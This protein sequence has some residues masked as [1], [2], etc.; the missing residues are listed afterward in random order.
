MDEFISVCPDGKPAL[1]LEDFRKFS[2]KELQGILK[3]YH[4]NISEKK[5]DLLMRTFAIFSRCQPKLQSQQLPSDS[6]T[7]NTICFTYK[8][9]FSR[10]LSNAIWKNDIREIPN[11]YFFQLYHYFVVITEKYNGDLLRRTSYKRLKLFQFFYEGYIK[12]MELFTTELFIYV[13]FKAKPSMKNKCY[14]VIVKFI[15][16]SERII[17]AACTCPAGSSI[18]CL[19]K[20]N[21][22]GATLFALEDFNRKDFKTFVEPLTCTSQLSKWNVPRDSSFNAAPIDKTLV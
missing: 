19:G 10:E 9:V 11:F 13:H 14:N 5:A 22:V 21:H 1:C 7:D 3:H 4:E 20:C 12:I 8:A 16:E 2:V 18:N 17:A 15:R 6:F